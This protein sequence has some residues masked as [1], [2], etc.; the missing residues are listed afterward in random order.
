MIGVHTAE[1]GTP[2]EGGDATK[3][4]IRVD[5]VEQLLI[6]NNIL[7]RKCVVQ[8]YYESTDETTDERYP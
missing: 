5:L 6:H 1:N 3:N 8:K 7:L 2:P 4:K